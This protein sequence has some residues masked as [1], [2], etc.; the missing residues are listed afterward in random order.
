MIYVFF[1]DML[2]S[3]TNISHFQTD[4]ILCGLPTVFEAVAQR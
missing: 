3:F 4:P 2:L 1:D